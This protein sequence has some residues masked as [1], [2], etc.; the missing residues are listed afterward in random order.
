MPFPWVGIAWKNCLDPPAISNSFKADAQWI[1][2]NGK[3]IPLQEEKVEGVAYAENSSVIEQ[4]FLRS[5]RIFIV[6][7]PE[8]PMR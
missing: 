1:S 7:W 6:V 4:P 3:E 2:M 5:N 8:K